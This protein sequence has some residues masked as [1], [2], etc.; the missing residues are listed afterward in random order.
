TLRP[1]RHAGTGRVC[2][3]RTECLERTWLRYG[4]R[5]DH[6]CFHCL[7]QIVGQTT[8]VLKPLL[9]KMSR[10]AS[11]LSRRA[12]TDRSYGQARGFRSNLAMS[13]GGAIVFSRRFRLSVETDSWWLRYQR[14]YF[15]PERWRL[16]RSCASER[17]NEALTEA[18]SS[19]ETL[20]RRRAAARWRA[21]SALASSMFSAVTAKSVMISTRSLL[22][23]TSP[24]PTA[25]N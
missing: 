13:P 25:K 8:L 4:G 20:S 18:T 23:S 7:R 2:G 16:T 9:S 3:R 22:T 6:S 1:G 14:T 10:S 5:A 17:T 12:A 24:S 21:S 11:N 19:E 15:P